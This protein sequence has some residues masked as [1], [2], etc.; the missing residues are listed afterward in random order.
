MFF[1]GVLL[2]LNYLD[3][4]CFF[5]GCGFCGFDGWY[6][7]FVVVDFFEKDG[8][9]MMWFFFGVIVW[10]L[11]WFLNV[12]LLCLFNKGIY[13]LLLFVVFG[14]ILFF[15]WECFVYGFEILLVLFFV[16]SVIVMIFVSFLDILWVDFV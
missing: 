11:G 10:I 9:G 8:Y 7:W 16:F 2:W 5:D 13:V 4:V 3:L 6:Y 1:G 15:V 12:C 14:V